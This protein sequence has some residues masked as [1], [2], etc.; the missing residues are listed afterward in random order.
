L[1]QQLSIEERRA[2]FDSS[3]GLSRTTIQNSIALPVGRLRNTELV[4][5]LSSRPG[6]LSDWGKYETKAFRTEGGLAR[7]HFYHNP[8]TD[9]TYYGMHYK[10]VY[11]H[12]GS[13]NVESGPKFDHEPRRPD[14]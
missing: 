9:D 2:I 5:E 4:N 13:W 6:N 12:Q 14:Q 11:D 8:V 3:G 1:Q 7:M 10:A